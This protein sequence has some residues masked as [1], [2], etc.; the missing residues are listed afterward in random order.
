MADK[1]NKPIDLETI[2]VDD[3]V[4]SAQAL[5]KDHPGGQVF[6]NSFAGRD[7][8]EAFLSYHRRKFPHSKM[9][10]AAVGKAIAIKKPDDDNDYLELCAI[11]EKVQPTYKSFAPPSYFI[12]AF[13]I[14]SAAVGLE[15]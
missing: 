14:V 11:L 15:V 13:I 4:Y 1:K 8:T 7:A 10:S 12:K 3:V 2:Q 9:T 6:V 5:A